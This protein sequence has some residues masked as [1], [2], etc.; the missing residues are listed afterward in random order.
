LAQGVNKVWTMVCC[1]ARGKAGKGESVVLLPGETSLVKL[2]HP[3]VTT[4][5]FYVGEL[6][7]E[8]LRYRTQLVVE[9]N[10]WL[11]GRL[12]S[13]AKGQT[14]SF[15]WIPDAPDLASIFKHLDCPR[16]RP[17]LPMSEIAAQVDEAIVKTGKEAMDQDEPVFKVGAVTIGEGIFA[18]V[19][20]MSHVVGDGYTFYRVYGQLGVGKGEKGSGVQKLK[21]KRNDKFEDSLANH[22]GEEKLNWVKSFRADFGLT[23]LYFMKPILFANL[24][25]RAWFVD[26][27]WIEGQKAQATVEGAVKWVSTNDVLTSWF[28]SSVGCD[29]GIMTINMRG[30]MKGVEADMAGNYETVL[31]FWPEE[32]SGPAGIRKTLQ[33][34]PFFSN[35]LRDD[36]PAFSTDLRGNFGVVTDWASLGTDLV[37]PDCEQIL[38]LPV[39]NVALGLFRSMI[40]FRPRPDAIGVLV[41]SSGSEPHDEDPVLSSRIF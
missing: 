7:T 23:F 15:I 21:P 37:L 27:D 29:Y 8:L 9:A 20:S 33:A 1:G 18:V 12:E 30:R 13:E 19:V 28:M 16:L 31:Q 32:F 34:G 17:G 25:H 26:S 41:A 4:V 5:T 6:P 35:A 14:G 36:T 39:F 24:T 40:I 11:A 38:H 2:Y 10:P 22:I 3:A